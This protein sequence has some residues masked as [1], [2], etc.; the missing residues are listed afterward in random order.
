MDVFSRLEIDIPVGGSDKLFKKPVCENAHEPVLYEQSQRYLW[1]SGGFKMA[2]STVPPISA[3]VS[4]PFYQ[5]HSL[6]T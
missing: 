2:T 6:E 3:L 4:L 5:R 1:S